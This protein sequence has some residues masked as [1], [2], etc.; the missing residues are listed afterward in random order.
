MGVGVSTG[1]V[2]NEIRRSQPSGG[3]RPAGVG[4][5]RRRLRALSPVGGGGGRTVRRRPGSR[6]SGGEGQV[7]IVK[8]ARNQWG[9]GGAVTLFAVGAPAILLGGLGRSRSAYPAE[10]FAYIGSRGVFG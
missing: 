2:P 7:N 4:V 6:R 8:W 10:P 5:Q 9:R 1:P 3:S